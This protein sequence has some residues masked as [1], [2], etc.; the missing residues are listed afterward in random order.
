MTDHKLAAVFVI[1]GPD[2]FSLFVLY[3]LFGLSKNSNNYNV[4]IIMRSPVTCIL[5]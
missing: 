3:N 2:I 1:A 4:K 5:C